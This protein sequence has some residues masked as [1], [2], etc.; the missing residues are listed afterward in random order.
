MLNF[1]FFIYS[2][3]S[4]LNIYKNSIVKFDLYNNN[5]FYDS[6]KLNNQNYRESV[7]PPYTK[8]Y[9]ILSLPFGQYNISTNLDYKIQ[10][11]QGKLYSN[12]SSKNTIISNNYK[13]IKSLKYNNFI[14]KNVLIIYKSIFHSLK[15]LN[16][17]I[18]ITI[19]NK[20]IYYGYNLGKQSFISKIKYF[21][22]PGYHNIDV[23]IKSN[24]DFIC[25]CPSI[26]NGYKNSNFLVLI[27]SLLEINSIFI[28]LS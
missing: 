26:D 9:F 20:I 11:F 3:G 19:D 10:K 17:D 14:P 16:Y 13:I 6:I 25:N 15:K 4:I 8:S 27:D 24:N 2:L 5:S 7:T 28:K 12:Y 18:I 22:L 1:Y 23:K 21:M